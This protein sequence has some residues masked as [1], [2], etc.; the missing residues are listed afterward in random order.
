MVVTA[1]EVARLQWKQNEKARNHM[2]QDLLV[3]S[4]ANYKCALIGDHLDHAS[5]PP[6]V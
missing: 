6:C 5:L 3:C 2:K 1:L 4:H